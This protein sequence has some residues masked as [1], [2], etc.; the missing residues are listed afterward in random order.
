MLAAEVAAA[1][2]TQ[3]T[4]DLAVDMANKLVIEVRRLQCENR[5]T[6]HNNIAMSAKYNGWYAATVQ[7][8]STFRP[9]QNY[10]YG[11]NKF[12]YNNVCHVT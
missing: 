3:Y 4:R 8:C 10:L 9:A 2:H 1:G 6:T 12:N 7:H 5:K 11:E